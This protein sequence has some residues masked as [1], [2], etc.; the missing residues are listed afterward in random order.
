MSYFEDVIEPSLGLI[1]KHIKRQY[2][3]NPTDTSEIPWRTLSGESMM[4]SDMTDS[5]LINSYKKLGSR[6]GCSGEK[7]TDIPYFSFLRCE[8]NKRKLLEL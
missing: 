6:L 5:H 4:I 2:I 3:F 7:E 1:P 8:L